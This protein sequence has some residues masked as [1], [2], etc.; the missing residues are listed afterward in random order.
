MRYDLRPLDRARSIKTK[1]GLLVAVTV[2]VA[3]VL[4]VVG[5]RLGL[6]PWATVPVTVAAALVVTQLLAR[7]M[8]SPLREM[9]AAAQRMARGDHSQRVRSTS[10]DE[11][12]ELARA[13]NQMSATLEQV[14]RHRRD[15]VANVSHEL[16][17]PI[18]AL[19]AVLE[20]LADG[21]SQPG[22]EEL[23][24]ALAQ[25]E[26]L[27]RLVSDLL[28]LSRV[29]EG[30]T[31]LDV[32]QVDLADL[33]DEAVAQARVDSLRYSVVVSP[34]GLTVPA[35]ADRLHQLLANLL[36]NAARHSPSDGQIRVAASR[37][38][39][40]VRLDVADDG[41][42]I[43]PAERGQVFERFTTS[44]AQNSGT[45]LGLAISRWVAQLHGGSIAVADSDHGC[46][47]QVLLPA[48]PPRSTPAGQPR[49]STLTPPAAPS[50]PHL[51]SPS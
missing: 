7:G 13:F 46:R 6:S 31:P 42:G 1:L 17:T 9:T 44:A 32:T 10:G 38:G 22:P 39:D 21:V 41:P 11:V 37:H 51:R 36:D 18:T 16:R 49:L 24:S 15:L 8:T 3:S 25:T 45:G 12:G 34:P 26:R 29:E 30:V 14:D 35:D 48:D 4:A 43:A 27:G 47:I 23:R 5:T 33:L 50:Q 28:D 20:N 40:Q 2:T 19:Q